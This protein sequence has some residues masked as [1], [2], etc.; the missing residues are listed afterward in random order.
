MSI[1]AIWVLLVLNI[2]HLVLWGILKRTLE[3]TKETCENCPI[4]WYK[5]KSYQLDYFKKERK[6]VQTD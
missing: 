1:F 3:Q 4:M 6:N 5:P 2:I